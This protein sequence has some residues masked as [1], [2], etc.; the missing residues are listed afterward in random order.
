MSPMA[1]AVLAVVLAALL[2]P[3]VVA[4][5]VTIRSE[6]WSTYKKRLYSG[7]VTLPVNPGVLT[8]WGIE[9]PDGT[10]T[11]GW[12]HF[13]HTGEL[14]PLYRAHIKVTSKAEYPLFEF[15]GVYEQEAYIGRRAIPR[16]TGQ[17][18]REMFQAIY[19]TIS[20]KAQQTSTVYTVPQS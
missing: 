7:K 5:T 16:L 14:R 13:R 9:N 2:L 6:V 15:N 10:I 8:R 12:V 1:A 19:L 18:H 11:S 17:P 4:E 3:A 20:R